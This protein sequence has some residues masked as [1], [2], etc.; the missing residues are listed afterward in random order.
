MEQHIEQFHNSV[1]ST[2]YPQ[3]KNY[4]QNMIT[5]SIESWCLFF[6]QH[7]MIRGSETNNYIEVMFRLF[8]DISLERTK[9]YNLTQP[10]DFVISSFEAYSKQRLLDLVMNTL[11]RGTINRLSPNEKDV[12]PDQISELKEMQLSC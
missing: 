9:A 10:T 4:I 6:R 12:L 11:N 8:K 7:L 5:N 3:Y 2:K 1:M